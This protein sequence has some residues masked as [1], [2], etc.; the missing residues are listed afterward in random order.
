MKIKGIVKSGKIKGTPFYIRQ[1]NGGSVLVK[2]DKDSKPPTIYSENMQKAH[3]IAAA[4]NN[5]ALTYNAR[6]AA[7]LRTLAAAAA[8][9]RSERRA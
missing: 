5:P 1:Q 2:R 4:N 8:S 3:R 6:L 7:A 9:E